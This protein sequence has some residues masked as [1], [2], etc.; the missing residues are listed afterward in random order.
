M[1]LIGKTAFS[2]FSNLLALLAAAYLLQG[3]VFE[4]TLVDLM[5]VATIFTAINFLLKPILK[6]VLGPLIILTL[7]LFLIAINALTLYL[8]DILTVPLTIQGYTPLIVATLVIGAINIVLHL[9]AKAY[10]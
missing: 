3:F 8:L 5:L 4:G 6:M 2:I 7:G 10:N 9:L 1:K